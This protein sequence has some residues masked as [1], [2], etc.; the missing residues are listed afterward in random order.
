MLVSRPALMSLM[1]SRRAAKRPAAL[2][3]FLLLGR[4]VG[5]KK[6]E[7][8]R[9]CRP[10]E[11]PEPSVTKLKQIHTDLCR[12]LNMCP[13]TTS[14]DGITGV[15]NEEQETRGCP[16]VIGD[17]DRKCLPRSFSC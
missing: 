7:R 17:E 8:R 16:P 12:S 9:P 10:W 3:L 11:L 15:M 2:K 5:S 4:E 13:W 1:T 14:T 6:P